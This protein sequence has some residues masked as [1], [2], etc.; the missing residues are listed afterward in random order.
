MESVSIDIDLFGNLL[1]EGDATLANLSVTG[2][3]GSF[4]TTG[5]ARTLTLRGNVDFGP[6][7]VDNP[8]VSFHIEGDVT[9]KK[10]SDL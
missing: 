2:S 5:A 10:I 9:I 7:N 3:P 6:A 8:D 4:T 1:L